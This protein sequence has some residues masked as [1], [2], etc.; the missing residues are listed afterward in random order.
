MLIHTLPDSPGNNEP[1]QTGS[2]ECSRSFF[3]IFFQSEK[4]R[5]GKR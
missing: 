5:E 2:I 3:I 4:R 1:D